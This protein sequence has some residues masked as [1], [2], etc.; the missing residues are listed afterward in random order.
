MRFIWPFKAEYLITYLTYAYSQTVIARNKRDYVWVMAR[1]PEIAD[2]DYSSILEIM[3]AQGYDVS[4]LQKV[5]Q[6]WPEPSG[7]GK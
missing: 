3:K 7:Q 1:K 5:P 6:R 2:A 4:K